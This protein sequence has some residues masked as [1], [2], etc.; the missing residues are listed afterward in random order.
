[1]HCV[2]QYAIAEW[3]SQR[4]LQPNPSKRVV[5]QLKNA[6]IPLSNRP[7]LNYILN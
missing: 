3:F 2:Q 6:N 5:L 4:H 1:M 7:R